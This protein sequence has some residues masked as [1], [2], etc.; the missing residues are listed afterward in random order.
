M[1][2]YIV[3]VIFIK[4]GVIVDR[5]YFGIS[6]F[7]VHTG[8]VDDDDKLSNLRDHL[9]DGDVEEFDSLESMK[10]RVSGGCGTRVVTVNDVSDGNRDF[11]VRIPKD[12][13]NSGSVISPDDKIVGVHWLRLVEDILNVQSGS[14]AI[15]N[16]IYYGTRLAMMA[17]DQMPPTASMTT[18]DDTTFLDEYQNRLQQSSLRYDPNVKVEDKPIAGRV[19]KVKWYDHLDPITGDGVGLSRQQTFVWTHSKLMSSVI[20]DYMKDESTFKERTES[21]SVNEIGKI[22]TE[23]S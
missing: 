6:E 16:G 1:N 3:T 17:L 20:T 2:G 15:Q 14:E 7:S 11:V 22:V 5:R 10:K 12:L 23:I 13:P 18:I 9:K 21:Y 19:H 4:N 8:S